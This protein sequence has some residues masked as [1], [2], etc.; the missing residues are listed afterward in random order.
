MLT[1]VYMVIALC[2]TVNGVASVLAVLVKIFWTEP[3]GHMPWA[4][5]TPPPCIF[6]LLVLTDTERGAKWANR[7]TYKAWIRAQAPERD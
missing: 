7:E 1:E 5:M 6:T 2:D 3:L 4:H